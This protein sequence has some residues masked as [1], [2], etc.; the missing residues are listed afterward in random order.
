MNLNE[1]LDKLIDDLQYVFDTAIH[2]EVKVLVADLTQR[3]EDLK[4][5]PAR[6]FDFDTEGC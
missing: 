5:E 3:V 2:P 4:I 6:T 1:K